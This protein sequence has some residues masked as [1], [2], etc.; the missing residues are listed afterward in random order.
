[1][2]YMKDI[3]RP[4]AGLRYCYCKIVMVSLSYLLCFLLCLGR[5]LVLAG[6]GRCDSPGYSA[7]YG[8][9]TLM[10]VS[11]DLIV[12]FETTQCTD[13]SSSVAMEK[14]GFETVL[15]RVQGA[16]LDVRTV[17]TDRNISVRKLMRSKPNIKHQ[18][19]VWHFAKNVAKHLRAAGK[20]KAKQPLLEWIPAIINHLWWWCRTCGGNSTL[21]RE[22]WTS[23]LYHICNRHSWTEG[24][25][26]CHCRHDPLTADEQRKKKWLKAGKYS[27]H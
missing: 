16:E 26:F 6:D 4:T 14:Y 23:I 8:T 24:K 3:S 20:T 2:C 18:F 11:T 27:L 19:D 5:K 17:V 25:V 22:M 13:T 7:K 12:D 21:L 1:M 10:D 15:D 9:Y